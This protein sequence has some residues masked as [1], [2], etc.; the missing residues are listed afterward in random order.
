MNLGIYIIYNFIKQKD[1]K[2]LIISGEDSK[3][4]LQSLITNDIN[5]CFNNNLIYSC[6]LTPQGKFI[7]DFFISTYS[8]KY[9]IEIHEKLFDYFLS[10]IKI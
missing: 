5:K 9:L 8:G 3:D 1:S 7:A 6:L 2:F 10:K 4:F